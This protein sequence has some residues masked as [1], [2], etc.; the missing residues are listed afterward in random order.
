MR[1]RRSFLL[2]SIALIL[3]LPCMIIG[4]MFHYRNALYHAWLGFS[5]YVAFFILVSVTLV[6]RRYPREQKR[7][8]F[9][10]LLFGL[11][12]EITSVFVNQTGLKV[13]APLYVVGF[14]IAGTALYLARTLPE[15]AGVDVDRKVID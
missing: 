14:A 5:A 7:I 11:W 13:M 6:T 8:V 15:S 9:S 4:S 10:W 2:G 3:S 12:Y 1:T